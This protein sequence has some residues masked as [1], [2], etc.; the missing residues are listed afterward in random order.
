MFSQFQADVSAAAQRTERH[1]L[2]SEATIEQLTAE[3]KALLSKVEVMQGE[4]DAA[5]QA[6]TAATDRGN[7]LQVDGGVGS[8]VVMAK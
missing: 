1:R 4:V 3:N 6:A 7:E 2:E 8:G 5:L